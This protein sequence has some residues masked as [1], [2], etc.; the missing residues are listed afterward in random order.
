MGLRDKQSSVDLLLN[1]VNPGGSN[2]ERRESLWL[3]HSIVRT[4]SVG[5]RMQ[6]IRKVGKFKEGVVQTHLKEG[7]N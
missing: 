6:K 1:K 5:K 4:E 7:K 3:A 2:S